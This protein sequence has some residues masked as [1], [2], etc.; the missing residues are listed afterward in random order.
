MIRSLAGKAPGGSVWAAGLILFGAVNAAAAPIADAAKDR[1]WDA[2]RALL[3][4]GADA[5]AT[6]ADGATALHWAA[7]WNHLDTL[8]RLLAAGARVDAANDYGATAL[9]CACANRHGLAVERLVGAGADPNL[10]LHS[11]E[12][13]LMRCVHTGDAAAVRAI[14]AGGADVRYKEPSAGQT[15]LMWAAARAHPEVT[16]ILLEHGADPNA[17]TSATQHLHGTGLLSTTSPAGADFFDYGGFTPLHFA[18]QSGD[19]V[20]ARLLLAAGAELEKTSA[21]GNGALVVAAMSG[22]GRLAAELLDLGADPNANGAGYTALHAAVL[23]SDPELAHTL[24]AAGADPDARLVRGTPIPRYTF[25]YVFTLK[26]KGA[27]PLLLAAKYLEPELLFVLHAGGADSTMTLPDGTTILMAAAGVGLNRGMTRR[28]QLLAPELTA[29][30]WR[31][32][33]RVLAT[34][35]AAL[36]IGTGAAINAI[37]RAGDTALHGA[38]RHGYR[39]VAALLADHG[40][41]QDIENKRGTTPRAILEREASLRSASGR[42]AG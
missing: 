27:T 2:V 16:R 40:G 29:A 39:E 9:W 13:V 1:Q 11:G 3:D 12:S 21:D 34:V 14:V 30:R 33:A 20:A 7:F 31:D 28:N 25:D 24:L 38:A 6:Q 41:N 17:H 42:P 35:E 37:N 32:E 26:E 19:L 15:A 8:D 5:S 36:E 4:Q 10:G 23:R 18:A 22:H